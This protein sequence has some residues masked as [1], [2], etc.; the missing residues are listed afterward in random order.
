MTYERRSTRDPQGDLN[1]IKKNFS[2]LRGISLA[3]QYGYE[4]TFNEND[5]QQTFLHH[6]NR[7]IPTLKLISMFI[8]FVEISIDN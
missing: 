6:S 2:I 5:T 1:L 8:H 4:I 7:I 3:T